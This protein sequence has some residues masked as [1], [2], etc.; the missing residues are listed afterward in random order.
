MAAISL[1][2]SF[3]RSLR[4]RDDLRNFVGLLFVIEDFFQKRMAETLKIGSIVVHILILLGG[5]GMFIST[6]YIMSYP[7]SIML[8]LDTDTV[9]AVSAFL[10]GLSIAI[11]A[12]ACIGLIGAWTESPSLLKMFVGLVIVLLIIEISAVVTPFGMRRRW[13]DKF[14]DQIFKIMDKYGQ[15]QYPFLTQMW[16]DFQTR[17]KC[18]GSH[19]VEDW[20]FSAYVQQEYYPVLIPP[21]CCKSFTSDEGL[22]S[23]CVRRLEPDLYYNKG[24]LTATKDLIW[25]YMS[26]VGGISSVIYFFQLVVLIASLLLIKEYSDDEDDESQ[27]GVEVEMAPPSSAVTRFKPDY[28]SN[29]RPR[30][31]PDEVRSNESDKAEI[32]L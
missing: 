9:T 27:G 26:V 16:D 17:W 6:I 30:Q 12:V 21:S 2:F 14:S 8:I 3:A 11:I 15:D 28:Q 18:C 29:L 24:C 4:S 19:K 23:R 1:H 25:R 31:L 7:S 13:E 32:D 20:S 5:L 10:C 22:R